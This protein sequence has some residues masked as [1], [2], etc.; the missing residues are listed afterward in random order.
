[1]LA[2]AVPYLYLYLSCRNFAIGA[3]GL[4]FNSRSGEVGNSVADDLPRLRHFFG[5]VLATRQVAKID[6]ST[7][8]TLRCNIA[9]IMKIYVAEVSSNRGGY[10]DDRDRMH[11]VKYTR[12]P[13]FDRESDRLGKNAMGYLYPHICRC[14][15]VTL[16]TC[17][18]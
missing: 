11:T 4:E 9:I 15:A 18:I 14:G 7:C 13:E 6:P 3:G 12:K 5:A 8:Y 10:S 2:P 17:P 1:M 16:S